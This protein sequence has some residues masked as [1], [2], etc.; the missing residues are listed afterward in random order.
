MGAMQ[1]PLTEYVPAGVP[2]GT[3]KGADQVPSRST[4]SVPEA[5]ALPSGAM[6]WKRRPSAPV[7]PSGRKQ[8]VPVTPM[9]VP[10]RPSVTETA[11]VGS[12]SPWASCRPTG[13]RAR[14]AAPTSV[15]VNVV[16]ARRTITGSDIERR[17]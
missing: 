16:M 7:M 15:A 3:T 6:S 5:A 8:P 14:T 4:G 12:A 2:L 17:L 13:T 1:V 10:V 9:A 11:R